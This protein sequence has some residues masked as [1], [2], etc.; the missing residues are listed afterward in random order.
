MSLRLAMHRV[1]R[2]IRLLL[3]LLAVL[4]GAHAAFAGDLATDLAEIARKSGIAPQRLAFAVHDVRGDRVL[5]VQNGDAPMVP[6]SNMK[7]LTT[8]A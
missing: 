6:A 3:P 7:V 2:P 1:V 5:A 8:G 4:V